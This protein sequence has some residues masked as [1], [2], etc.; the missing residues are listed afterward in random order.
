MIRYSR[1]ILCVLLSYT[2]SLSAQQ[3]VHAPNNQSLNDD[4]KQP[5][6]VAPPSANLSLEELETE[7]DSLRAQK[8]YLDAIDYY[9]AGMQKA[10]SAA[11]H[12]KAGIALLQLARYSEAR[13]EFQRAIKMN[14]GY[15]EAHNNLG[16][17]DYQKKNYGGAVK[18]YRKAIKLN[19][20]SASFHSNLGS[21]YFSDKDYDGA[22]REYSLA[23]QIDPS[24][25]DP[26]PSGG[27]S[28]KLALAGHGDRGYFHYMVAKMYGSKGDA[29]HCRFYL[30]KATEEGY[31][32]VK[33]ALKDDGFAL[34]RKDP[35]FVEFVKSLKPPQLEAN[36]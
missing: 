23:M 22:I 34:L 29:E 20:A 30:S 2:L 33:N 28:I 18:E 21:A 36:N 31:Q 10:D 12:N 3:P 32:N 13:K 8:D 7:G 24:I 14:N 11:L 4:S 6:H 19:P 26:T 25:F 9:K 15:A 5:Q 35:T 17:V 1:S 16:V 27:T